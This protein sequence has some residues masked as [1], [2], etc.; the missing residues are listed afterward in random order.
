MRI[1]V[2]L[3]C[4]DPDSLVEF[5]SVALGY[6]LADTLD[7]YRVLVPAP[8]RE[9]GPYDR[10]GPVVI[11]AGVDTPKV[12]KNRMHVDVHP[13]D[14]EAHLSRLRRLGGSFVGE[15]VERF[16]TWWQVMTDPEG[17]E[18]CV[19]SGAQGPDEGDSSG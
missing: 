15:R 13:E 2:V 3:D 19:V 10:H 8:G 5:W 11:L 14:A 18:L 16:G 9:K 1:T 6:T 17:N 4:R 7:E 12:G